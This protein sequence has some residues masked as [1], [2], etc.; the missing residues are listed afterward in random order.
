MGLLPADFI[1]SIEF[2]DDSGTVRLGG[3]HE[4]IVEPANGNQSVS[5]DDDKLDLIRRI[6]AVEDEVTGGA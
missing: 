6:Q 3:D 5:L 1:I 2:G 4:F